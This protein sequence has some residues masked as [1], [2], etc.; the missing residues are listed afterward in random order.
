MTAAADFFVVG[1]TLSPDAP[2]YVTR[3][4]DDVLYK[5]LTED[6][7]C[8]VL[9]SRQVG[10]S[11]LMMRVRRRLVSTHAT[12]TIDLQAIGTAEGRRNWLQRI[13]QS[14]IGENES[15]PWYSAMVREIAD[16]LRV[17]TQSTAW[18]TANARLKPDYRFYCLL[19]ELLQWCPDR[20]ITIFVD[21]I[22]ATL[23]VPFRQGL[24]QTVRALFNERAGNAALR[25]LTFVLIGAARPD[26]L[27]RDKRLSPF[28]VG[29]EVTLT[30]FTFDEARHL[31][32]GLR[33]G[34]EG[35]EILQRVLHWTG[36]HPFLTQKVCLA[37]GM[38]EKAIAADTVDRKVES[39]FF[40][41]GDSGG[42]WNLQSVGALLSREQKRSRAT[43]RAALGTYTRVW[44]GRQVI[45]DPKS[46]AHAVLK[47]TGLV[48]KE[49]GVL[50]VRNE[51]YRRVFDR[52]WANR[53]APRNWFR[54]AGIVIVLTAVSVL[55][56]WYWFVLPRSDREEIEAAFDS[57]QYFSDPDIAKRER[58]FERWNRLW[59][60]GRAAPSALA[61]HLDARA[62]AAAEAGDRDAALLME[63]RAI[64][65]QETQDR[66][67]SLQQLW[68]RDY[69]RL[70]KT[71]IRDPIR[72]PGV[73]ARDQDIV[74]FSDGA[75]AAATGV[76]EATLWVTSEE[77]RRLRFGSPLKTLALAGEGRGVAA[78]GQD[79]S[80]HYWTTGRETPVRLAEGGGR[81]SCLAISQDA[82]LVVRGVADGV[83]RVWH[84]GEGG[85]AR[86][87]S[88]WHK[89]ACRQ[90]A[91][92]PDSRLVAVAAKD[93]ISLFEAAV[94]G[95]RNVRIAAPE[96]IQMMVFDR[97]G[98]GLIT[99][100]ERGQ[101][102]YWSAKTGV[103]ISPVIKQVTRAAVA[104][105]S[106][107]RETV[108]VA[109]G[110]AVG[111]WQGRQAAL[112]SLLNVPTDTTSVA[113]NGDGRLVAVGGQDGFIRLWS[114]GA[115]GRNESS[116]TGLYH[117]APIVAL[118]FLEKE[119][120]LVSLGQT[121]SLRWWRVPEA[122]GA[123]PV[124]SHEA[125]V[126][127]VAV[128]GDT[129]A[130]G[131]DSGR[132]TLW[133]ANRADPV[134]ERPVGACLGSQRGGV[135]AVALSRD[136]GIVA[137]GS[138]TGCVQLWQS[139]EGA[140]GGRFFV[141]G[142]V[143]A[144]DVREN[145]GGA[146]E[147]RMGVLIGTKRGE[148]Q[149]WRISPQGSGERVWTTRVRSEVKRV[150]AHPEMIVVGTAAGSIYYLEWVGGKTLRKAVV[151]VP[152][153]WLSADPSRSQLIVAGSPNG[154]LSVWRAEDRVDA[155]KYG[156]PVTSVDFSP[157]GTVVAVGS[158][159][160][161]HVYRFMAGGGGARQAE[162]LGPVKNG[163]AFVGAP[164][165][166][167][168]GVSS[169]GHVRVVTAVTGNLLRIESAGLT[170][171]GSG[172]L[173][174]EALPSLQQM[175][176]ILDRQIGQQQE[177]TPA[178]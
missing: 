7:L 19:R 35:E 80:L 39:L 151:G 11:S 132:L 120:L 171:L 116:G 174:G 28:N 40:G 29:D 123:G 94:G 47:L 176:Q 125:S 53:L 37:V 150:V 140:G 113:V 83:T 91:I 126:T 156:A 117:G 87:V 163:S 111:V 13:G 95:A 18:W 65:L 175:E 133:T 169:D 139:A 36:G 154:E 172:S 102:S 4:A 32:N 33:P 48:R 97:E 162:V 20:P 5:K 115:G 143:S 6:R 106:A 130:I 62:R 3:E 30:D 178:R 43:L 82:A 101:S 45:D 137:A 107:D 136:G 121:G 119:G 96:R 41:G 103:P 75:V 114:L 118:R 93:G 24:F 127:A 147:G 138:E 25:R 141:R 173:G 50:V 15:D 70:S 23:A 122:T 135:R 104:A 52:E 31:A 12:V 128:G 67:A 66:R 56:G 157:D 81:G 131:T 21:E 158:G 98:Q 76:S 152:V 2:S 51:I 105:V 99:V 144:I 134:W 1:G 100:S 148:I 14:L 153:S 49:T 108:V 44:S 22:D 86:V 78:L 17:E 61:T 110:R 77:V 42:D 59:L 177:A 85:D 26:D 34:K 170:K 73:A 159:P 90:V 54:I 164:V 60:V 68:G 92:S 88:L 166:G 9:S 112:R 165:L 124:L 109:A 55:V 89:G 57:A 16:Q 27:I 146:A 71:V 58:A 129:V 155:R 10:K 63:R 72:A 145:G 167:L 74:T 38:A 8:Y 84:I 161:V 79:N 142:G 46:D 149:L 69:R 160:W 168:G 64:E